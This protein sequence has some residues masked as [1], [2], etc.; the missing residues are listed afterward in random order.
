MID[1]KKLLK[2]LSDWWLS[3]TPSGDGT[4]LVINGELQK[5]PMMKTIEDF[6]KTVE[7]QPKVGEWIPCS[8]GNMPEELVPVNVTWVNREPASY[9]E[10]IKDKPF[11]A[12]AIYYKGEWYWWSAVCED[13]LNDTGSNVVDL[14]HPSIEIVAWMP[15]PPAFKGE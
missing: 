1:E 13:R 3:E 15:L 5:T 2:H 9:Y 7:Q 12:T 4:V 11:T 14:L 8:E 6:M 10:H